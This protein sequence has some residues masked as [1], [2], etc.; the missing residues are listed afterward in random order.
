MC[1]ECYACVKLC[2]TTLEAWLAVLSQ[3][4]ME[5][6]T[7]ALETYQARDSRHLRIFLEP[8]L[9]MPSAEGDNPG[10]LTGADHD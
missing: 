7:Y 1:P 3:G 5:C 6:E 8:V 9:P 2:P 10:R 4:L